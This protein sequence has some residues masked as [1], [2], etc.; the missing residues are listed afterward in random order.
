MRPHFLDIESQFI[1][2]LCSRLLMGQTAPGY[3]CVEC[4]GSLWQQVSAITCNVQ[5]FHIAQACISLMEA[6]VQDCPSRF[7]LLAS[8]VSGL[9][10]PSRK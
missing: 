5:E 1:S 2:L 4:N 3:L 6:R 9:S 8:G 7:R 10:S